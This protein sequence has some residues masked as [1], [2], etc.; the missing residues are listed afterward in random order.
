M[1]LGRT[2]EG[3]AEWATAKAVPIA[4]PEDLEIVEADFADAP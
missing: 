2:D 4:D 1:A 3:L